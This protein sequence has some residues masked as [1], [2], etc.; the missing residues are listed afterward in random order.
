MPTEPVSWRRWWFTNPKPG[1]RHDVLGTMMGV[2]IGW[3]AAQLVTDIFPANEDVS[4]W[5]AMAANRD[6]GKLD[7]PILEHW[8]RRHPA[9]AES[10]NTSRW[11]LETVSFVPP[12]GAGT[13]SFR[14]I[15]PYLNPRGGSSL[16]PAFAT[17]YLEERSS[18]DVA[19]PGWMP[20]PDR[21][22]RE[23]LAPCWYGCE[24]V[25]S[26]VDHQVWNSRPAERRIADLPF[27]VSCS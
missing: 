3:G 14:Y 12:N 27:S 6:K 5:E 22:L 4:F 19:A 26:N 23:K 24:P 1:R 7:K 13:T 17:T 11:G 15:V 10:F 21:T 18:M 16:D 9:F 8:K 20:G 2:N 25:A